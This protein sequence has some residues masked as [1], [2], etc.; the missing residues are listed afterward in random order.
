MNSFGSAPAAR[1][2]ER[3]A[4]AMGVPER[5]APAHVGAIGLEGLGLQERWT[6]S[7]A[8]GPAPRQR[9]V[10]ASRGREHAERVATSLRATRGSQELCGGSTTS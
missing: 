6:T 7:M 8:L 1:V 2:P 9:Q 3:L 10:I 4:P 5:L